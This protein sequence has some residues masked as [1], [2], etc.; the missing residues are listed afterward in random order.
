MA[1]EPGIDH[2]SCRERERQMS[3]KVARPPRM[4]EQN[5]MDEEESAFSPALSFHFA[6]TDDG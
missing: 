5:E 4:T 3:P 1:V 2:A 6:H